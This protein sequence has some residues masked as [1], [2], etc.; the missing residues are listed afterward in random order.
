MNVFVSGLIAFI[1]LLPALL[2]FLSVLLAH[3]TPAIAQAI[4]DSWSGLYG[5]EFTPVPDDNAIHFLGWPSVSTFS[6]HFNINFLKEEYYLLSIWYWAL[7]F[8]TVYY[9]ST[10]ASLVFKTRQE[11]YTTDDRKVLSAVFSFQFLCLLPLFTFLS[12]DYIRLFFYL[13]ASSFALFLIVSP[14]IFTELFPRP[15]LQGMQKLNARIDVL[16]PPSRTTVSFL[17]MIIGISYTGYV[18]KTIWMSTM[19][20]RIFLLF[21]EPI[22]ILRDYFLR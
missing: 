2:A 19:I 3:G 8:F 9:I 14:K 21:S 18:L 1:S 20:Y 13:T 4:W 22:L 16:L 17:M 15:W 7:V 12:I 10:N 5:K 11:V 6:F